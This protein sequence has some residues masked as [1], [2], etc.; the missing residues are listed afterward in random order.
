M[1]LKSLNFCF[2]CWG[3][4]IC[5]YSIS[6]EVEKPSVLLALSHI[7][8]SVCVTESGSV[9]SLTG[10]VEVAQMSLTVPAATSCYWRQRAEEGRRTASSTWPPRPGR[11]SRDQCAFGV[12]KLKHVEVK[13]Q[14][15]WLLHLLFTCDPDGWCFFLF[16]Y[17]LC[18]FVYSFS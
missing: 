10:C 12:D 11:I 3:I 4:N 13:Q 9:R 5:T 14:S 18:D 17:S 1:T 2:Y 7:S 15:I 8:L 16:F 6:K